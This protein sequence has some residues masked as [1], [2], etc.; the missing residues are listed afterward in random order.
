MSSK[1]ILRTEA[2]F[3]ATRS[4]TV[5]GPTSRRLTTDLKK[6]F[7]NS[8]AVSPSPAA[9]MRS[10][11]TESTETCTSRADSLCSSRSSIAPNSCSSGSGSPSTRSSRS[12]DGTCGKLAPTNRTVA[13]VASSS[14]ASSRSLRTTSGSSWPS[15]IR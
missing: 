11:V 1:P 8:E 4:S 5:S 15:G 13:R 2:F 3:S 7:A 12:S 6:L 10:R 9:I 14:Q